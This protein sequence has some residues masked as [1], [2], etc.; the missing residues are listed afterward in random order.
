MNRLFAILTAVALGLGIVG[1]VGTAQ[2]AKGSSGMMSFGFAQEMAG[3]TRQGDFAVDFYKS[4]ADEIEIRYG[5]FGGEVTIDTATGA[6]ARGL[7]Y[8]HPINKNLAGYGSL[9]IN[10][11]GATTIT[12]LGAGVSYTTVSNGLILNGNGEF[13]SCSECGGGGA[14]QSFL[15][16]KG[17]AFYPLQTRKLK[18]KTYI[19]AELDL[20]LSP[21]SV[22]RFYG[23][24]RFQPKR[25]VLFD[26][27]FLASTTGAT[28]LATPAF[29][30]LNITF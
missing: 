14:S 11:A 17:G 8:K 16:L 12:N 7:G 4:T 15:N 25:N 19:A 22:T 24:A 10:T 28:T 1:T 30:R 26:L 29:M 3:T 5:A 13:F 9:Y 27:G 23:G 21:T 6:N 2:A 20:Q 18:G